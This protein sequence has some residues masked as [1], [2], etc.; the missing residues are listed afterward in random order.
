VSETRPPRRTLASIGAVL[1]GFLAT[2]VLSVGTDAALHATGVFP[3]LGR[4]MADSLFVL[5]TA[6]RIVYTV[7]G[8]WVA[9]RLAPYRPMAHALALGAIGLVAA[10]AGAVATWHRLPELGP[11]WYPIALVV[12]AIPCVWAGARLRL[13]QSRAS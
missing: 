6:Y 7:A 10:T 11:A 8:G 12:S 2:F 5:A 13:R 4:P 3:P 1:A 9:A